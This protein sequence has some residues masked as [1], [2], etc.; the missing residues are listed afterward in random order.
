MAQRGEHVQGG[1]IAQAVA[2]GWIGKLRRTQAVDLH[3]IGGQ[4]RHQHCSDQRLQKHGQRE[5]L[6]LLRADEFVERG[7]VTQHIAEQLLQAVLRVHGHV[8]QRASRRRINDHPAHAVQKNLR[9]GMAIDSLYQQRGASGAIARWHRI[10]DAHAGR[11]A[12]AA[13]HVSG[14]EGEV[15]TVAG[16][17]AEQERGRRVFGVSV[18]VLETVDAVAVEVVL[19]RQRLGI[20]IV[21]IAGTQVLQ[22]GICQL[23]VA[24]VGGQLQIGLTLL[25]RPLRI[26]SCAADQVGKFQ[27]RHHR[28]GV[29]GLLE[30]QVVG[31]GRV[32]KSNRGVQP[33]RR[34]VRGKQADGGAHGLTLVQ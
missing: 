19:D 20:G 29:V 28:V 17:V 6:V 33:E 13:V 21:G 18:F 1:A 9:P 8:Y 26:T 34:A 2:Q 25:W 14:G 22:D 10:A 30:T 5:R 32:L 16:Q 27:Q 7:L 4:Q 23:A 24:R 31:V 3:A 12:D 11:D 15:H